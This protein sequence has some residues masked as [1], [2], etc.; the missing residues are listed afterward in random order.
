[1]THANTRMNERQ[2]LFDIKGLGKPP[3]FKCDSVKFVEWLRKTTDLLIAAYGPH[4]F[5]SSSMRPIRRWDP[6]SGKKRGALLRHILV[7]DRCTLQNFLAGLEKWKELVRRCERSTSCGTTTAALET[8]A[9]EPL[10]PTELE[11]HL[12]VNRAR[13]ITCDQVRNDIHVFLSTPKS[14]RIQGG[15]CKEHCRP[16]GCGQLRH[17]KGKGKQGKGDGKGQRGKGPAQSQSSNPKMDAVC[18]HRGKKGHLSAERWAR[19]KNSRAL[20]EAIATVAEENRKATRATEQALWNKE[21]NLQLRIHS[22]NQLSRSLLTWQRL[23]DQ[24]NHQ[25]WIQML[26]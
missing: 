22:R 20:D 25:M 24:R 23:S 5:R 4:R 12:L 1:M 15:R 26:G 16:N 6:L 14:V 11:Q 7:P 19:P 13:V 8:A 9:L 2:S 17:S 3:M 18:W 21:T 10:V